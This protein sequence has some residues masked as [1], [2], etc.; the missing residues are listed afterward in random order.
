VPFACSHYL[1]RQQY[2]TCLFALILG[3]YSLPAWAQSLRIWDVA[4]GGN[5]YAY[6]LVNESLTWRVAA[7]RAVLR[8][9][10]FGFGMG[11]LA[12]ILSE[13]E[14]AFLNG[15]SGWIGLSDQLVE[16][17]W[18]WNDGTPGVW[19]DPAFF[20]S[21]IQ[22]LFTKWGGGEPNN[23]GGNQDFAIFNG[24][25]WDDGSDAPIGSYIVKYAPGLVWSPTSTDTLEWN[26]SNTAWLSGTVRTAWQQAGTA[27][28]SGSGAVVAV[29]G[30]VTVGGLSFRSPGFV[31]SG[32]TLG[33]AEPKF[34]VDTLAPA[35]MAITLSGI[36]KVLK[37]GSSVLTLI[38]TNAYTGGTLISG[39][40]LRLGD[41]LAANGS[42]VG[43]VENN[44]QL[45]FANPLPQAFAGSISGTGALLKSGSG[46]LVLSGSNSYTGATTVNQGTIVVG[47]S[48][49]IPASTLVTGTQVD[50][51]SIDLNGFSVTVPR[52]SGQG[53][54]AL[55]SGTLTV[56]NSKSQTFAG[57]I[58][59]SGSV[60]KTGTGTLTLTG[61]SSFLGSTVINSGTLRI[62]DG[63]A[64][65]GSIASNIENNSRLE[66]ANPLPETYAGTLSGTGLV[67]KSGSGTLVVVGEQF[68]TGTT[69]VTQGVLQLGDGSTA[70]GSFSGPIVANA[71]LHFANASGQKHSGVI[72]G[73]GTLVKSGAGTLVLTASNS[74]SGT[75]TISQGTL[76]LG[77]GITQNGSVGGSIR[78]N[79]TL[80]FANVTSQTFGGIISGSGTLT[81][82][83]IGQLTLTGSQAFTGEVSVSEGT[84]RFGNGTSLNGT[85]AANMT[86]NAAVSFANPLPQTY[87]GTISGDGS[88]LKAGSG[89]LIFTKSQLYTG[90]TAISA[91][92]LQLGDGTSGNV[93]LNGDVYLTASSASLAFN[94]PSSQSFAYEIFG[95]GGV[96]KSGSGTLTLL[97]VNTYSGPTNINEGTVRLGAGG[98]LPSNSRLTLSSSTNASLDINNQVQQVGSLSGGTRS[99][100]ALR[101]GQ[102]TVSQTS[103]GTFGG[104]ITGTNGSLV[105]LGS[106]TLTFT[107]TNTYTGL[108]TVS[109]GV[110]RLGN[111]ISAGSIAGNIRSDAET[112]FANPTTQV[113]AGSISGTGQLTKASTGTLALTGSS[114]FSGVTRVNEGVLQLGNGTVGGS[115]RGTIV[116]N[117]ALVIDSNVN[118]DLGATIEG[119]GTLTKRGTGTVTLSAS[120]SLSGATTISGGILAL[121][122]NGFLGSSLIAVAPGAGLDV[123]SRADGL[124]LGDGRTLAGG[125]TVFGSVVFGRGS[126][127]SPGMSESGMNAGA[128]MALDDVAGA[129]VITVPEPTGFGLGVIGCCLAGL[130]AGWLRTRDH[131]PRVSSGRRVSAKY[132][133]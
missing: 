40:T 125:G 59:G 13:E 119:L 100:I 97:G 20:P 24:D 114:T 64:A 68:H 78:N 96:S 34:Q 92:T 54:I 58:S 67:F 116:N 120:N 90:S 121:G 126:T 16:G 87:S 5:G 1:K 48:F 70:N 37:T 44:S 31:L 23:W 10:P 79:A 45:E 80:A 89:T 124:S 81:K 109:E 131:Q 51:P 47:G 29:Q 11:N 118:Q 28:F 91:G 7:D 106:Q 53:G 57:A 8:A 130:G 26:L 14:N 33:V 83:G 22:N 111:G 21:P 49:A 76:Q 62:G 74:L 101:S 94:T 6:E 112:V 56:S 73:T 17:E 102:L 133:T 32:G 85:V 46:T 71:Q 77:D 38:G 65:G 27:T 35:E 52:L 86:N 41:G 128:M 84:L 50:V 105:K 3:I 60:V 127:L 88:V 30:N 69:T 25:T 103:A 9:A 104:V 99:E 72:S 19:Q 110:L 43:N 108:T 122:T 42:I 98:A 18:R 107:N 113:Y 117:T 12:S 93:T 115:L 39:G 82:I 66:F 2:I 61:S 36:S 15:W 95:T 75:T 4:S 123:L 132:T 129:S 63:V 55:G